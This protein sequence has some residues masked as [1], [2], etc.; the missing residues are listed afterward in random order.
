[1]N[2]VQRVSD[3]LLH[4]Q[5]SPLAHK[6]VTYD[7]S[8]VTNVPD[9]LKPFSRFRVLLSVLSPFIGVCDGKDRIE[10]EK[11]GLFA[12]LSAR[13]KDFPA[14]IALRKSEVGQE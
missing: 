11:R 7:E 6:K 14:A 4:M 1:M 8:E 5:D 2:Y 9:V 10:T 3:R 13:K 12:S